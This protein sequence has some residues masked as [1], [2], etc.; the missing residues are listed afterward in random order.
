MNTPRSAEVEG[1]RK[2]IIDAGLAL[3]GEEGFSGLTQPKIAMR[4]GLRQ[5]HLTYY[6]PTRATLVAA[7][8]RAASED[9]G[10]AVQAMA[11]RITSV[12]GAAD[13]IAA[14]TMIPENT[15]VLAALNQVADQEPEVRALFNV[16]TDGLIASLTSILGKLG[17]EFTPVNADLLHALFVGLSIINLATGRTDG[18]IRSKSVLDTALNLLITEGPTRTKQRHVRKVQNS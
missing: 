18:A 3:L 5:S 16:L 10:A 6:Y 13:V 8:A 14:G 4:T 12:A 1:R 2:Q 9:Q 7:I 11:A 17:I 15:R